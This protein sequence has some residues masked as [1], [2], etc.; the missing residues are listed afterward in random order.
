MKNLKPK[1]ITVA[2][3]FFVIMFALTNSAT[4]MTLDDMKMYALHVVNP[5][6]SEMEENEVVLPSAIVSSYNDGL[7]IKNRLI[8]LSGNAIKFLGLNEYYKNQ[9]VIVAPNGYIVGSYSKTSTDYEVNQMLQLKQFCEQYDTK[10]I[11]VSAPTKY[12]DDQF[13][14]NQF[15]I[16]SY[17]NRNAELFLERIAEYGVP[18]IDLSEC[19]ENER[20]DSFDMFYRTDHHWTGYA[21]LWSAQH[22]LKSLKNQGLSVDPSMIVTEN[23]EINVIPKVWLGE[24]GKKVSP[25]FVGLDDFIYVTPIFDSDLVYI[26]SKN[27]AIEGDFQI[28]INEEKMEASYDAGVENN[29]PS[30]HYFYMKQGVDNTTVKN[31]NV[32]EGKIL[33]LGDS[34]SHAT[35]PYLSLGISQID[36]KILR[37][38]SYQTLLD[39]IANG[40]YDAVVVMYAEFMI[41][42]HDNVS[43]ANYHMFNFTNT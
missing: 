3:I 24:Q 29:W 34:Y 27:E 35:I 31:K 41:G 32:S 6:K 42:A 4:D 13:M 37:N 12:I 40:Q 17:I 16:N 5:F 30:W 19:M 9:G 25:S 22:I 43:S 39:D 1:L 15:G 11:Y 23:F 20:I 14:L 36:S 28:L 7:P 2:Y 21:G 18:Y 8:N 33:F 38:G 26:N 10:L